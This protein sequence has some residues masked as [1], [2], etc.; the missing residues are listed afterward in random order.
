MKIYHC[1]HCDQLVFYEN[2]KCVNC[3]HVLAY[4][5]DQKNMGTLESEGGD[6]WR[7]L[8]TATG[9]E[10]RTYRLCKNYR[11]E[12]VCN[13]AVPSDQLDPY[14]LSC[15]L[16]RIIPDLGRP[17]NREAWARLEVFKRRLIHSLISFELP[18]ATK[19]EDPKNG[20]AFDFL[21]DPDPEIQAR[22]PSSPGTTMG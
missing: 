20:L 21:A 11:E 5:P 19:A 9:T 18:V 8:S 14:C 4:L 10:E 7:S 22:L 3:G 16:T 6:I 17:E 15:R 2:T 13:W 12:N 1:G